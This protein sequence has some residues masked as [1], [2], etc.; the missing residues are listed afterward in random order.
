MTRGA[1]ARDE[2][3]A[4]R[5]AVEAGPDVADLPVTARIGAGGGPGRGLRVGVAVVA[6][7]LGLALVKPWDMVAPATLPP[8]ADASAEDASRPRAT[9]ALSDRAP[10]ATAGA[11]TGVE[12]VACLSER[13]WMA[14]VD[15]VEGA[16]ARRSWTRL[17]LVPATGPTDPAMVVTRAWAAAVPRIGFCAPR[18]DGGRVPFEVA[19]WRVEPVDGDAEDAGPDAVT[20]PDAGGAGSDPGPVRAT[21]A[22]RASAIAPLVVAGGTIADR[23]ALYAPPTDPGG[24]GGPGA[25]ADP[26]A[27][28]AADGGEPRPAGWGAGPSGTGGSWPPG[29]YVFRVRLPGAGPGGADEAWFAIELLGPW[30]SP[31]AS[32]TVPADRP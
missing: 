7:A 19:G 5:G 2:T 22:F 28:W 17:V 29:R 13:S 21:S 3:R 1:G 20:G 6:I 25:G 10:E 23:G 9:G 30:P 15:Q 12:G 31:A 26:E 24:A 27:A 4:P 18:R 8:D 14:V 32:P 11:W 16:S